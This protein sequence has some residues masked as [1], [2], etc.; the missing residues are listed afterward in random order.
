MSSKMWVVDV[1]GKDIFVEGS[2]GRAMHVQ[3]ISFDM[4]PLEFPQEVE[5]VVVRPPQPQIVLLELLPGP[6]DGT[7]G[8]AVEAIRV[9]QGTLVVIPQQDHAAP[10]PDEGQAFT[11][12][13]TIAHDITQ[14][15]DRVDLLAIDI[16]QHRLEG[17]EV[18]VDVT[19][20][21]AIHEDSSAGFGQGR[22]G[23]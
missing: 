11:R 23:R 17:L 3:H 16:G 20:D 21:R 22:G 13:W 14:A 10:L 9:E 5:Q 8:T 15:V 7:L 6:A 12:I 4:A 1:L 2:P 18:S 19:D